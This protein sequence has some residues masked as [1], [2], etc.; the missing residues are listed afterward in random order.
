MRD[1][2]SVSLA[3]GEYY[4]TIYI[5]CQ[6]ALGMHYYTIR[7]VHRHPMQGQDNIGARHLKHGMI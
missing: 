2:S 7:H 3:A 1:K 5:S 6:N 4:L